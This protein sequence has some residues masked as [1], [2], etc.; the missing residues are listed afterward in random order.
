MLAIRAFD[1]TNI[2]ED[3]VLDLALELLNQEKLQF[4]LRLRAVAMRDRSDSATDDCQNAQFF[5][6]LAMERGLG[7]LA[8]FDLAARKFPFERKGLVASTLAD[9]ELVIPLNDCRDNVFHK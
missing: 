6:Q 5:L 2:A 1:P 4:N 9:E 3:E 7:L 8:R